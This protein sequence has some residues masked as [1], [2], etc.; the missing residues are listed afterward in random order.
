[1]KW[2]WHGKE[3]SEVGLWEGSCQGGWQGNMSMEGGS[4]HAEQG[5]EEVEVKRGVRRQSIGAERQRAN[6][7]QVY[8][9]AGGW[10]Q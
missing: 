2:S 9:Q 6:S 8:C 4:S 7:A 1:M 10:A 5:E 3:G